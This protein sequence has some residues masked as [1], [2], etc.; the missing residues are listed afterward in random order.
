MKNLSVL[1]QM[2]VDTG[3]GVRKAHRATEQQPWQRELG[4]CKKEADLEAG[5]RAGFWKPM[6]S[7]DKVS[8]ILNFPSSVL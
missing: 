4:E 8:L 1:F 6:A 7:R 5:F 3:E 2:S